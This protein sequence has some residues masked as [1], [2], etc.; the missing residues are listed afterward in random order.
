MEII[1]QFAYTGWF[2]DHSLTSLI[3]A[4]QGY[5][6]RIILQTVPC[7]RRICPDFNYCLYLRV[8]V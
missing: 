6:A 4:Q 7:P 8:I 2:F 1:L 5:P 3:C